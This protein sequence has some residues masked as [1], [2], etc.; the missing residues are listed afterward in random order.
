MLIYIQLSRYWLKGSVEAQCSERAGW[1]KYRCVFVVKHIESSWKVNLIKPHN[2]RQGIKEKR[3]KRLHQWSDTDQMTPPPFVFK[4]F[5]SC[6][7]VARFW[8]T[9]GASWRSCSRR[10][11]SSRPPRFMY[12]SL[13]VI[14]FFLSAR[15]VHTA[16]RHRDMWAQTAL[17]DG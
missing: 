3:Y 11:I 13:A 5:L 1:S 10:N 15:K 14:S 7:V 12:H 17:P 2:T 4:L 6:I 8:C 16:S 9:S